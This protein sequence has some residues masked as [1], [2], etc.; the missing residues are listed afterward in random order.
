M[1]SATISGK[2][3]VTAGSS[4]SAEVELIVVLA[5][6]TL[7][8]SAPALHFGAVL[9]GLPARAPVMLS[10]PGPLPAAYEWTLADSATP[11]PREAPRIL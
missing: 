9:A 2:L 10:N 5:Y 7:A 1:Q 3:A 11:Q 4:F 6:P 8:L